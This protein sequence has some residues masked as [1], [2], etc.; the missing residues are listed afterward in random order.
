MRTLDV[1]GLSDEDLGR[2]CTLEQLNWSVF[3]E[4]VGRCVIGLRSELLRTRRRK[5]ELETALDDQRR[6]TG[7]LEEAKNRQ[8]ATIGKQASAI[9]AFKNATKKCENELKRSTEANE[10]QREEVAQL[11]DKH[12]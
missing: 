9:E 12:K 10:V 2:L 1:I 11:K 6:G 7:E 3:N 4:S 8:E 5:R